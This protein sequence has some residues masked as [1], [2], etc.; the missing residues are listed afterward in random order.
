M[1]VLLY[2]HRACQQH[3]PGPQHPECPD[4]LRAVLRALETEE[5]SDHPAGG[6]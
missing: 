2:T 4:R 3:D 5:F 1:T 6:G